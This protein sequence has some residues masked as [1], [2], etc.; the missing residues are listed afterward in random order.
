MILLAS[1]ITT[2]FTSMVVFLITILSLVLLLLYAKKKLVP[3]GNVI[4]DINDGE[5]KFEVSPG[6]SLLS[7]LAERKIFI[8]SAC[9]G[10]GTCGMCK[11][12][13]LE[14]GGTILPTEV[15]FFTRK[16]VQQDWRL[17]CQVKV[18]NDMKIHVHEEILGVKKWECEVVS[19][20]NVASF[21]K[22]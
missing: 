1:Q 16:Q 18:R 2:I 6:S 17:G 19:N 12:Q 5:E 11:C 8:P 9:G 21:I 14:G 13:V 15:G 4:I 10:G 20:K 7:A 22:E 3:Q